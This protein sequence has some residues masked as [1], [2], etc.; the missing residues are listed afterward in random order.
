MT[1][2]KKISQRFESLHAPISSFCDFVLTDHDTWTQ[3]KEVVM[4]YSRVAF[5]RWATIAEH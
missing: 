5:V 2:K 4:S 1:T 3:R